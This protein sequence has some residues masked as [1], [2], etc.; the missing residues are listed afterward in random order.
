[1]R[2]VLIARSDATATKHTST[3]ATALQLHCTSGSHWGWSRFSCGGFFLVVG[4]VGRSVA[5]SVDVTPKRP[6]ARGWRSQ[7]L[8][9]QSPKNESETRETKSQKSSRPGLSSGTGQVKA[10]GAQS[11]WPVQCGRTSEGFWKSSRTGLSHPAREDK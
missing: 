6:K 4:Q 10:S 5:Q 3:T 9:G 7:R 1:M 2:K 11:T 8:Q